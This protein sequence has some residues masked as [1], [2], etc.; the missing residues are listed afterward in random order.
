M[1]SM[2]ECVRAEVWDLIERRLWNDLPTSKYNGISEDL[3]NA[4]D[5]RF[6][7]LDPTNLWG[8]LWVRGAESIER[9]IQ[10]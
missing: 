8:R 2:Q 7:D 3:W 10:E 6:D 5:K 9:Q 4:I 1:K